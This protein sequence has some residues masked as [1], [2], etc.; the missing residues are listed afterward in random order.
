MT[1]YFNNFKGNKDMKRLLILLMI[2][3]IFI[4]GY[5]QTDT[6]YYNSGDIQVFGTLKGGEKS[7]IWKTYYENGEI[8]SIGFYYK[9]KRSGKWKW[10]YDNG[11][12]CSKEKYYNDQFIK[13]KFWDKN[14]KHTTSEEF[15]IKPE[16]PGGIDAFRM[17]VAK[18]LVYPPKAAEN[19]VQGRVYVEFDVNRKGEVVDAHIVRGV[20]NFIDAEALRVI[21][22]SDKW[23]PGKIHGTNVKVRYT[24]PVVFTLE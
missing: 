24:F 14:G 16:Y 10:Y 20:D 2:T 23:I 4:F 12:L 11:Q 9:N 17:M 7:G 3:Q 21:N 6:I 8:E 5:S 19:G 22:L 18:N 15:I 1:I 13:G